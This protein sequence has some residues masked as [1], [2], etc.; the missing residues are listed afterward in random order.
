MSRRYTEYLITNG[1]AQHT[2]GYLYPAQTSQCQE[3]GFYIK[4]DGG[5]NAGQVVVET[6]W[7]ET[8]TDTW[9]V[10]DTINW[11][12]DNKT[13][14]SGPSGAF[15]VLRARISTAIGGG[16]NVTVRAVAQGNPT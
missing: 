3:F 6:A 8:D 4:F 14:Y 1:I 7:D 11:A 13:H 16:G 10:V 2:A 5:S 9:A 15:R 12:A